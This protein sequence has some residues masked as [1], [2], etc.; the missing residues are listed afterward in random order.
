MKI[1]IADAEVQTDITLLG[2]GRVTGEV[3]APGSQVERTFIFLSCEDPHGKSAAFV[4][5]DG[6]YDTGCDLSPGLWRAF[7][8]LDGHAIETAELRMPQDAVFN[9]ALVPCGDLKVALTG[10]STAIAGRT[11]RVRREDGTE[12][13]RDRLPSC[14]AFLPLRWTMA[15]TNIRGETIV[16]GLRPGKYNVS[17]DDSKRAAAVSVAAGKAATATLAVE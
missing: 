17:V 7:F 16:Y 6:T 13:L 5:A 3:S 1:A 12:V 4:R 2:P 11:V 15:P 8:V 14:V 9:A 10:K